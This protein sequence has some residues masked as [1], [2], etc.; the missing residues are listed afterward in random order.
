[1]III[2]NLKNGYTN[3][4][5]NKFNIYEIPIFWK[6][7]FFE[8]CKLYPNDMLIGKLGNK[9]ITLTILHMISYA[10]LLP[11]YYEIDKSTKI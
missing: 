8:A 10:G 2:L 4:D 1:M 3:M 5:I 11:N 7:Y 6:E 9:G